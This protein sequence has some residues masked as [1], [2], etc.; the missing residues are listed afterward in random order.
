MLPL[1]SLAVL[2]GIAAPQANLPDAAKLH[3]ALI[4]RYTLMYTKYSGFEHKARIES[5]IY[6]ARS[7]ELDQ[8]STLLVKERSYF[9]QE[10]DWSVLEYLLDGEN[11][12]P[13]SY[14]DRSERRPLL[15][16]F[17]PDAKSHYLLA[18]VGRTKLNGSS[19]LLVELTPRQLTPRHFKGLAWISEA[20]LELLRLEGE[21]AA[22]PRGVRSI[23]LS[24]DFEAQNGY[25]R[26]TSTTS[27][28][29][30]HVPLF[31]PHRRIVSTTHVKSSQAI[32]RRGS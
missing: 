16:P 25:L 4:E 20:P 3:R 8:R 7:G 15:A 10:R 14:Q 21:I 24:I 31:F 27:T 30:V 18:V 6:H 26:P 17:G 2:V 28:V 12:A 5:R 9:E 19:A 32:K 1:M 13:E 22:P 11:Q 23:E 29:H